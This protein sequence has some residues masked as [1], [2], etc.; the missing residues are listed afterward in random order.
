[1]I[2]FLKLVRRTCSRLNSTGVEMYEISFDLLQ[3]KNIKFEL[4]LIDFGLMLLGKK[5]NI[6][7][8]KNNYKIKIL[9]FLRIIIKL[10][11]KIKKTSNI[12]KKEII[13]Y[14]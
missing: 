9:I 5:E 1:M 7:L 6:T 10:L 12:F 4:L 11:V 2:C 3:S 13:S 14:L 8:Y